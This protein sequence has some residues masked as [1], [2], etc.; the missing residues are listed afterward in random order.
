MYYRKLLDGADK[1]WLYGFPGK[2]MFRAI[3]NSMS[4]TDDQWLDMA[5]FIANMQKSSET[6]PQDIVDL[7]SKLT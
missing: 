5:R 6:I 4:L 7:L 1:E 3:T 2:E